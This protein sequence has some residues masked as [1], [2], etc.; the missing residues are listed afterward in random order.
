M[1]TNTLFVES[2]Q[3]ALFEMKSQTAL[4]FPKPLTEEFRPMRIADFCGLEKPKKVLANLVRAPRSCGLLFSGEPGTGKSSLA[5]AFALELNAQ[6]W[7]I[8]SADCR[9]E[10]LQETI[11]HCHYIPKAGLNGFHVILID[12]VDTASTAAQNFLLSKLD[13]TEPVPNTIFVFTCNDSSRLEPRFKSR[14]LHLE[15]NSYGAGSEIVDLLSRI[16]SA[17]AGDTPAPNF[18]KIACGNVRESL[19]KLE[20]E[21]L[22]C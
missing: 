2:Q 11:G 8:G 7:H 17:K 22:A 4:G 5:I 3:D 21:L 19:Q 6:L 1:A 10:K 18:R 16:W 9:I 15:F 13:A 14:C 12:E 20:V